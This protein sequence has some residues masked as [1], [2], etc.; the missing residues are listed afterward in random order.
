MTVSETVMRYNHFHHK[1]EGEDKSEF[2]LRPDSPTSEY[3]KRLRRM[4]CFVLRLEENYRF[5]K[6]MLKKGMDKRSTQR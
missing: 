1:G 2:I 5:G 3:E 6:A 4:N